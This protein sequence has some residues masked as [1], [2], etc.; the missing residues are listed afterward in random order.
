MSGHAQNQQP[1]RHAARPFPVA[2]GQGARHQGLARDGQ[3]V[4]GKGGQQ[5]ELHEDLV[6]GHGHSA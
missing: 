1:V 2:T 5:P 4:D 3:G 6:G